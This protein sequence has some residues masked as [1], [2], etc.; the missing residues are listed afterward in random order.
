MKIVESYITKNDCYRNNVNKADSRYTN[1]QKNGPKGLML[2]SVG[3][4]Q[5]DAKVFADRWNRSNYEVAVHAVL[6]ADG[7]VYQCMPWNYRGWH[8]GGN[9]NNTHVGVEMTEP[10]E[11]TYTSG[12]NFTCSN[13]AKAREHVKGCYDTAV[14][15][16]A[17]LC[18]TYR[19]DP[20]TDIISHNEG[21]K[22]GVASGHVDPEH[23]WKGLGMSY[24][25]DG[26]RKDVKAAM[27]PVQIYRIRKS[28]EDASSQI[29]A[30][31]NLVYAKAACKPG[32]SVYD[33][34]G[35]VV[36]SLPVEQ[37]ETMT[38]EQILET[39]G[40]KYIETYDDLP[41]WA[42]PEVRELLDKGYIKGTDA[43]DPDDI[44]M[45][46]SDI[47]SIIVCSRIS[48]G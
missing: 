7:T 46:M 34:N 39:I 18:N 36:Y 35:K 43:D 44:K 17:Q 1:F 10:A 25:M 41:E 8:C 30:Y 38:K 31:S 19:L 15:L 12:A 37:E 21:G 20:L 33:E 40:D 24:T 28:W 23:L 6:Q 45:F 26:F 27:Q 14:V 11:I 42:K 32:Y 22:K 5:P 9:A 13:L 47:K 4:G 2:H 48:K 3:V 16:F 29:G